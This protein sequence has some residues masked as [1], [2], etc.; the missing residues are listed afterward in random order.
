MNAQNI[1]ALIDR[2]TVIT[3]DGEVEQRSRAQCEFGYRSAALGGG[4]VI[5]ATLSFQ[6]ATGEEDA[7]G[8]KQVLAHRRTTQ[9]LR[10]PSAGCA[11]KNPSADQSAGRLID[12]SG[13][14]GTRVGD[15]CVSEKH[16][17]FVVN[18]GRSR[19]ADV[20]LLMERI[21]QRVWRDH[22]LWLEPEVRIIGERWEQPAAATGAAT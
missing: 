10:L 11:F 6:R 14:K 13:L 15:A 4:L 18:T 7:L 22:G 9:E 3:D 21:Q 20:L 16:A 19:S 17:N 5:Q 12:L 8:V 1:G 2:V